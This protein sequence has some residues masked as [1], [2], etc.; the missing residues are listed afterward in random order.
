M[1]LEL[2]TRRTARGGAGPDGRPVKRGGSGVA[3]P[4][5]IGAA[6]LVGVVAGVVL[7]NPVLV[8]CG[9]VLTTTALLMRRLAWDLADVMAVTR[10][11]TGPL[12]CVVIF[13]P[14]QGQTDLFRCGRFGG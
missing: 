6:G 7:L 13:N 3:A 5:I 2:L 8:L 11:R 14:C 4:K 10:E 12:P 9:L 1:T